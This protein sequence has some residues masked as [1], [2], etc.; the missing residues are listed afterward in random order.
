M[1]RQSYNWDHNSAYYPWIKRR[2]PA[3]ANVLDVGC[4]D[5]ALAK[6]LGTDCRT[7]LGI[8]PYAPCID[9]ARTEASGNVRFVCTSFEDF[10]GAAESF[11][12][13]VFC[14]SLHHTD[15]AAAVR[16]AKLML[17]RG[18]VLIIVGLARPSSIGDRIFEVLR[19]LP[20][21]ISSRL[22]RMRAGEERDI[23][24]SYNLPEMRNV[25]ALAEAELA[26]FT[27]RQG[28]HYRFLLEWKK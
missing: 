3:A 15:M 20:S 18:G 27:M 24:T 16:K 21:W 13:V 5:G 11:D 28:L 22:H 4:G 26:G 14:A 1:K 10:D 12:A 8:D 19:V 6:Y 9:R 2:I 23:P 17:R 25:R 7:V